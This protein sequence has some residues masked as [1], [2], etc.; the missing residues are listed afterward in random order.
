MARTSDRRDRGSTPDTAARGSPSRPLSRWHRGT[1]GGAFTVGE[2][3]GSA[4]A[5]VPPATPRSFVQ[6][7]FTVCGPASC[8]VDRHGAPRTLKSPMLLRLVASAGQRCWTSWRG[9]L[10]CIDSGPAP[11]TR[12]G[13]GRGSAARLNAHAPMYDSVCLRP[14]SGGGQAPGL[15]SSRRR[16]G[17]VWARSSASRPLPCREASKL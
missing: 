3:S 5:P 16:G 2:R 10:K 15:S 4:R 14:A 6:D 17:T 9:R 1:R 8:Y 11:G 13:H 12:W 7:P